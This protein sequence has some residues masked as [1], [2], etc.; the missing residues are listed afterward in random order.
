MNNGRAE[1]RGILSS[2]ILHPS[3]FDYK[4]VL[5]GEQSASNID[6]VGS[7][8]TDLATVNI[9]PGTGR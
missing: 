8:P 7:N 5:L 2:F 6:A 1:Q 9:G 3:S 4:V